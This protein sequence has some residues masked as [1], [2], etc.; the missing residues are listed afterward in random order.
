MSCARR[1]DHKRRAELHRDIAAVMQVPHAHPLCKD[2][3][4]GLY[5]L[6]CD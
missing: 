5:T 3:V 1:S 6:A 2:K 4:Q